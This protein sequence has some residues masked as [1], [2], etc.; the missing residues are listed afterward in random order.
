MNPNFI[1]FSQAMK[2]YGISRSFLYQLKKV[3]KLD[4]YHILGKPFLKIS[5][6]EALMTTESTTKRGGPGRGKKTKARRKK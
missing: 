4:H 5:D 6:F 2:M 1:S 3:G